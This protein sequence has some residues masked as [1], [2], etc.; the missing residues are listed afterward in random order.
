MPFRIILLYSA[1]FMFSDIDNIYDLA[2]K[3]G[4]LGGK[5]LGAGGGGYFLF[6]CPKNKQSRLRGALKNLNELK[7]KF[8]DEGTKVII[9]NNYYS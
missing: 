6:Y 7:F 5:I 9:P 2:L 3:N 1:A 4:A 8:D